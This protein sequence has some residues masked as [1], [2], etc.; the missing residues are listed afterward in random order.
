MELLVDI[1]DLLLVI[2]LI[3]AIAIGIILVERDKRK[4]AEQELRTTR[5]S[6]KKVCE[7]CIKEN[8]SIHARITYEA[9]FGTTVDHTGDS[10]IDGE[11]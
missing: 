2:P 3:M 5:K 6:L 8:N 11:E 9:Y 10:F 4:R 7:A 1:L